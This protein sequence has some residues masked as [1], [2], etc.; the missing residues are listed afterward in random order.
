M[1][2]KISGVSRSDKL[3]IVQLLE[4]DLNQVLH[5]EFTRNITKLVI[6]HK[7]IISEHQYGWAHKTC[8][9][10]VPKNML[11]VQLLIQKITT[12]IVFDNDAKGCYD[13]IIS[14][15]ALAALRRLGYFKNSVNLLDRLWSELEH[16]VWTGY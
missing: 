6:Q 1:L 8:M 5:V 4:A 16:R 9:T 2:E 14:G 12:R 7:G 13:I 10:P 3:R 15:V 11:T